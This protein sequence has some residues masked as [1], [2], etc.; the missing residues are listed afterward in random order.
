MPLVGWDDSA[1]Q[2]CALLVEIFYL[3]WVRRAF[4][5]RYHFGMVLEAF[6]ECAVLCMQIVNMLID[7]AKRSRS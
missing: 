7:E 3:D 5:M 6:R 4:A 1:L 2:R